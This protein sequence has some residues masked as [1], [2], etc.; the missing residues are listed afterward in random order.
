MGPFIDPI[1]ENETE[2]SST[3]M[4]NS[5]TISQQVGFAEQTS[6]RESTQKIQGNNGPT[7]SEKIGPQHRVPSI[8]PISKNEAEVISVPMST[9]TTNTAAELFFAE[10]INIQQ[11]AR[12]MASEVIRHLL[13]WMADGRTVEE[14]GLRASVALYC[15]RPDLVDGVTLDQI[16]AQAGCS[17]QA[18]HKLANSFRSVTGLSS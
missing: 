18:V 13:L 5:T 12:T 2:V 1:S 6:R 7:T 4:S 8:D 17:R 15:I 3:H 9:P 14:R 11:E 10:P 16:G